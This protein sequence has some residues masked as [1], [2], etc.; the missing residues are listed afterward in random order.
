M[1]ERNAEILRFEVAFQDFSE[2]AVIIDYE[3]VRLD[4]LRGL[5]GNFPYIDS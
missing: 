3:Q 1:R 4:E 2:F 5:T